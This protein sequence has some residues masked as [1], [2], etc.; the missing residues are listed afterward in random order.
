VERPMVERL[1]V[2]RPVVERQPGLTGILGLVEP[3]LAMIPGPQASA[4]R[5]LSTPRAG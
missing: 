4:T 2:E 5:A 3:P 1:M